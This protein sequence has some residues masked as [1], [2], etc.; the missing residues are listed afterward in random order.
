MYS[1]PNVASPMA[2]VAL[3]MVLTVGAALSMAGP[4]IAQDEGG[5]APTLAD[6]KCEFCRLASCPDTSTELCLQMIGDFLGDGT[7]VTVYCYKGATPCVVDD[8]DESGSS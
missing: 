4:S 8:P 6:L 5:G 7:R 3:L 2:L 1:R